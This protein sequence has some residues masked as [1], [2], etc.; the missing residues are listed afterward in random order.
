MAPHSIRIGS[1]V[2]GRATL[3]YMLAYRSRPAIQEKFEW[4][5]C[6]TTKYGLHS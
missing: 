4:L 2:A 6:W 3:Y 1:S 5:K